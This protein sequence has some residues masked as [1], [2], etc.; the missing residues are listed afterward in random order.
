MGKIKN[1]MTIMTKKIENKS[2][3]LSMLHDVFNPKQTLFDY[4]ENDTKDVTLMSNDNKK[5]KAHKLVISSASEVL[6]NVLETDDEKHSTIVFAD[7]SGEILTCLYEFIYS[8]ETRV[9]LSK[10]MEFIETA[11]YLELGYHEDLSD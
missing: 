5:I 7:E 2:L 11:K 6:K 3:L 8:G 10:K 4:G 9:G 1:T